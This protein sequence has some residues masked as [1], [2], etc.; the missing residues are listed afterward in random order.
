MRMWPFFLRYSITA[1]GPTPSSFA[2]ALNTAA[3][4]A[5]CDC[6][7]LGLDSADA[8]PYRT[9]RIDYF[10]GRRGEGGKRATGVEKQALVVL[11]HSGP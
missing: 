2:S 7:Q 3:I 10:R 6:R 9:V 1:T 11:T 8:R 5:R 4:P